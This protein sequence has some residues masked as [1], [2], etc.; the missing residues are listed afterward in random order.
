[1]TQLH[2][3]PRI[4]A[5]QLARLA[6]VYVR[7]STDRQV[8]E[9]QG[10]TADQRAQAGLARAWGWPAER[11]RILEDL[12]LSGTDIAH[13]PKFLE[14]RDLIRND[15][16]G[17][18]FVSD[19]SRLGR[20]ALQQIEFLHDCIRYDVAIVA[21]GVL[22]DL[23]D[24]GALLTQQVLSSV[25]EFDNARRREML[26]RGRNA[27]LDQG[28]AVT[29]PP[30][31]YLWAGDGRWDVDP[32]PLVQSSLK[33]VFS[34]FLAERSLART[35]R[36]LQSHGIRL[37]RRDKRGTLRWVEP[38]VHNV[39]ALLKHPVYTGTYVFGRQRNE[40]KLGRSRKG[41]QR[42]RRTTPDEQKVIP[43][44]HAAYVSQE[45]W[46]E[47]QRTLAVNAPAKARRNL[48]PGKALLQGLVRCRPHDR[49]MA[50]HYRPQ[51]QLLRSFHGYQC[52]G[53]SHSGG[54]ACGRTAGF[55]LDG[56]VA[57]E[58]LRRLQPPVLD[59]LREEWR[60]ARAT[61]VDA[62]Y[63]RS[64]EIERA[65]R[66]AIDAKK[67][68]LAVDPAL[69]EVS[70]QLYVEWENAERRVKHLEA[71]NNTG[72][73]DLERF[74]EE[75]W[76]R[77]LEIASQVE[78]IWNAGTTSMRDRK[79]IV[80]LMIENVWIEERTLERIRASIIWT[81][82]TE[83]T[84]VEILL[85]RYAHRMARE[86]H[87]TGAS[88]EEIVDHLNGLAVLNTQGNQWKLDT[89]RQLLQASRRTKPGKS[90]Q[91]PVNG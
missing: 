27:R 11:I 79:E 12:G 37:P 59:V 30:A 25:A 21:G 33:A 68:A 39:V 8:I 9:N 87:A 75:V 54:R 19:S 32:D 64:L 6:I 40:P 69:G 74:T 31:G 49:A 76:T 56:A 83:P 72:R 3:M 67:R 90:R 84:A 26:I 66:A 71:N 52:P 60:Q 34:T 35:V 41:I 22:S 7:Q 44:H 48:G 29:R 42:A 62:D 61:A 47:I 73:S 28:R 80:R 77:A 57:T 63:S 15:Q 10:S 23:S 78:A 45:E 85:P 88:P 1:M 18:I 4:K 55:H 13:R 36:S 24:A 17:A 2:A 14:M 43:G 86:L 58:V 82:G 5:S 16:V 53:E 51:E 46:D 81:D 38:A 89:V 50:V 20:S 91:L 70:H 65:R